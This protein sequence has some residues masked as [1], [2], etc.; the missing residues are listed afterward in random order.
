MGLLIDLQPAAG[1][2]LVVGGG[3]IAARKVR[4]LAEAKFETVVVAPATLDEIRS[5]PSVTVVER[6][7][8]DPDLQLRAFS[9]VFA[10]TDARDLNARIGNLARAAR[11]P[12]V[13]ADAAEESTFYTPATL[14]EGEV[15]IAVSTGGSS[16][17]LARALR[18][19][20]AS[21][22]APEWPAISAEVEVQRAA[23]SQ[24]RSRIRGQQVTR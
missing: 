10:C 16:P 3:T 8:I 12:V 20:I 7:F 1:P 19:R 23:R 17:G 14:R 15:A 21:A 6:A 11:I 2:A 5:L 4:N 24:K 13:V 22:L 18:E 9:V